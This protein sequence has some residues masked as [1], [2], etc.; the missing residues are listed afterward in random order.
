MAEVGSQR[1]PVF[2][3]SALATP[4]NALSIARIAATPLVIALIAARVSYPF[5][6]GVWVV[7][8]A[9]DGIDG[10]VA[11]R[12][13]ATRSGA[14]LDPLA[15]KF[16][17]LG[18]LVTLASIGAAPWVPVGAIVGRELAISAYRSWVGRHGVSVPATLPAKAKTLLQDLAVVVCVATP[19]VEHH[20][21]LVDAL[22]WVAAVATVATGLHYAW[23][24]RAARRSGPGETRMGS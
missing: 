1:R 18:A 17:V 13:G 6:L 21:F 14:F 3:P 5:T 8:A 16:L 15:D 7:L 2:G 11:R 12:Q 9:T 23:V 22:V 10:F 19:L 20:R 24:A 4:A